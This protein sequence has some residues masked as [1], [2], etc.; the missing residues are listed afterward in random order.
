LI[1]KKAGVPSIVTA[2]FGM[3]NCGACPVPVI[4]WHC[5]QQQMIEKGG[6]VSHT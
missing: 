6:D 5:L 1:S 3:A 2:A 4:L